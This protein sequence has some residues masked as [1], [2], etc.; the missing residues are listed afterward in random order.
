VRIALRVK[1]ETHARVAL[2]DDA[3]YGPHLIPRDKRGHLFLGGYGPSLIRSWTMTDP[4]V[5]SLPVNVWASEDAPPAAEVVEISRGVD[6][7]AKTS[8]EAIA[9][10]PPA[11]AALAVPTSTA[12]AGAA[13]GWTVGVDNRVLDAVDA[14]TAPPRQS[15]IVKGTGLSKGTVSKAVA[16]LEKSGRIVRNED[17]TLA[18]PPVAKDA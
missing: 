14:A 6:A 7:P 11:P 15:E 8:T 5:R 9:A 12:P 16:R 1:N 18:L 17:G 4:Q 13:P 3:D 2:D 10:Q